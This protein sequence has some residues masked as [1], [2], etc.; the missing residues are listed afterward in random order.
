MSVNRIA[1]DISWRVDFG[2][3]CGLVGGS[4]VGGVGRVR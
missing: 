4:S 1:L 3:G 2:E